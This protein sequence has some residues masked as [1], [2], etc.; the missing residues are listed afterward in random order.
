MSSKILSHETFS[1]MVGSQGSLSFIHLF[2]ENIHCASCVH[3]VESVFSSIPGVE[4]VRV[5]L[6]NRRVF[7]SW[8]EDLVSWKQLFKAFVENDL[9][10]RPVEI[11]SLERSDTESRR[12]LLRYLGVAAFG[13]MNVMLF[14][15]A[16]W[17]GSDMSI[18]T[19]KLLHWIQFIITVPTILYSGRVFFN[20]AVGSFRRGVPNM[21]VPISV[22][23][24]LSTLMSV[25]ILIQ[26]NDVAVS[27]SIYFESSC[28]LLFILLTGRYFE[29]KVRSQSVD[30][31]E[32]LL[33]LQVRAVQIQKQDGSIAT[34]PINQVKPGMKM[35]VT[36]GDIIP[37]DGEIVEGETSLDTHVVNG[38]TVFRHGKPGDKVLS[39]M[40]NM[41][42]AIVVRAEVFEQDSFLMK[43]VQLLDRAAQSHSKYIKISDKVSKFYTPVVHL[44]ALLGFLTGL[45]L[46]G[47]WIH[48]TTIAIAVLVV[49]C[50]CALALAVPI[51][52]SA[53]LR[54]LMKNGILIKASEA[55]ERLSSV[56]HVVFD[57]T[58]TLTTGELELMNAHDLD[59][60]NLEKAVKLALHSRHP[61]CQS[62]VKNYGGGKA[63]DAESC[64]VKE[65]PAKGLESGDNVRLG[66]F[67]FCMEK[68][69]EKQKEEERNRWKA[70]AASEIWL[71]VPGKDLVRFQFKDFVRMDCADTLN[72]L[73]ED[74]K[75]SLISGDRSEVVEKVAK[76]LGI[77]HWHG[78]SLPED[79]MRLVSEIEKGE[80][81][82]MVG[83][84]INDAPALKI[85]HSSASFGKASGIAQNSADVILLA[86]NLSSI[87]F[88][89]KKARKWSVLVKENLAFS[90]CYNAI[91]IP[92]AFM[93]FVTPLLAAVLMSFSSIVVVLNSLRMNKL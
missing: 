1:G 5:H 48:A 91:V 86:G 56:K 93:G 52:Q 9:E 40:I 82:L 90:F 14:S 87:P 4:E 51:V 69:S 58:G 57:K 64:R 26:G 76:E 80:R 65:Y 7:L 2:V 28:M 73:R 62:L 13:S 84:G 27:R 3:K 31:A 89:L 42:S 88:L 11:R 67:D 18:E 6:G 54:V 23:L 83:D 71:K 21:D 15:L 32:D 81:T 72:R 37:L 39:G 38:E 78:D 47:S 29:Q 50:P 22:A 59:R 68:A 43:V 70:S 53:S 45:Y 79:K 92:L 16:I 25:G 30:A 34:L 24:I 77:T 44:V 55:L 66:S 10:P 20:S 12:Y 17:M 8:N 33:A 63:V 36:P 41:E 85:A 49:S 35:H 74:Y 46:S 19:K 61:L 60:E 75:I